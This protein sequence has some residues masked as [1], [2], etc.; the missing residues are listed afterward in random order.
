M[1]HVI[2]MLFVDPGEAGETGPVLVVAP[3]A[4]PAHLL[5]TQITYDLLRQPLDGRSDWSNLL[6]LFLG[7]R[8][9]LDQPGARIVSAKSIR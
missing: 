5:Q 6:Q 2:A 7:F 9:V 4:V 1:L 8:K 3:V